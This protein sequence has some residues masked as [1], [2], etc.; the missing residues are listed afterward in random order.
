VAPGA[1][2]MNKWQV[3]SCIAP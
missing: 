1:A 2:K 3:I